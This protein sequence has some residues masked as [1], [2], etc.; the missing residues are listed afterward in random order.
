M[1]YVVLVAAH[2]SSGLGRVPLKDEI[3]GPNPVCATMLDFYL[4]TAL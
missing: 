1:R 3:T 2:S 4:I